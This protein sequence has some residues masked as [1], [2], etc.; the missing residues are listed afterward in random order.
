MDDR[1][2]FD[3][4]K[5]GKNVSLLLLGLFVERDVLF[6]IDCRYMNDVYL[7]LSEMVVMVLRVLEEVIKDSE[8]GFFLMIEGS[9]I[10]Y[11]GYI[12]D[13]VV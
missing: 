6:E 11:V 7:S 9:R 2:G 1:V 3:L 5:L 8:K 4:F 13:L 10:D 12:N